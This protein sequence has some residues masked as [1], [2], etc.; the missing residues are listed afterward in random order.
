[1]PAKTVSP[2]RAWIVTAI[3]KDQPGMV[4]GVTKALFQ[5]GCNLE[6]SSMTRLEG[7]FAI[8]LIFSS[9]RA[10]TEAAI[11]KA[12]APLAR[13]LKLVV[14]VKPLSRAESRAPKA[15]GRRC[16]ISVYG[17]D[18]PGIVYRVS[19][20]LARAGANIHDVHTHRSANRSPSLYLLLLEVELPA[21]RALSSLQRQLKRVAGR[22][23]VEVTVRPAEAQVL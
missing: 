5:L 3:G 10:R 19:D 6:D 12:F 2:P 17:A 1:M 15:R 14:R 23:G 11:L 13:R 7:E 21:G 8:M 16:L 4:A 18:R 22:L 9:V 20:A